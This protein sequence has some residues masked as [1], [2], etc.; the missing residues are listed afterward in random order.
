MRPCLGGWSRNRL[1]SSAILS[2]AGAAGFFVFSHFLLGGERKGYTRDPEYDAGRVLST[3]AGTEIKMGDIK[4]AL[5]KLAVGVI[6]F[7]LIGW[8][9]ARDKRLGGALLTFPLLNGIAT[10]TG[11]DPGSIAAT[12]YLVIM[13]NSALFLL[14]IYHHQ[15]MPPIPANVDIEAKIFI[16][17]TVWAAL[18]AAGAWVLVYLR[19]DLPSG[20]W[21][22]VFQLL[23]VACS[24][25]YL[26]RAPLPQSTQT[27]RAL[28]FNS[29]GLI[30][31]LCFIG[32]FG[33]LLFV[34]HV[35]RDA[36][37]VGWG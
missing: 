12:V 14:T 30:R 18:W 21:L 10:L 3:N 31:V 26:W 9:G 29:R 32:A 35:S 2:I 4:L 24:V 23:A 8:I 13:W 15:I 20:R 36:R 1:P 28:W 37:S 17:V 34:A 27:F 5:L 25:K 11:L 19:D 6:A 7:V 33:I 22:F 16:R